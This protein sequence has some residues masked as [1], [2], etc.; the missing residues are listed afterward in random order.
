MCEGKEDGEKGDAMGD[1]LP[2]LL[3]LVFDDEHSTVRLCDAI[4]YL[5]PRHMQRHADVVCSP[6]K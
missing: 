5:V 6:A 2:R 4:R 1:E 3:Y